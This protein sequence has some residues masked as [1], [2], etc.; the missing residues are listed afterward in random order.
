MFVQEPLGRSCLKHMRTCSHLA[1]RV[2]RPHPNQSSNKRAAKHPCKNVFCAIA[3]QNIW[4]EFCAP[5]RYRFFLSRNNNLRGRKTWK[6]TQS[7]PKITGHRQMFAF[8][9]RIG[10]YLILQTTCSNN[11]QWYESPCCSVPQGSRSLHH[12]HMIHLQT[13][14]SGYV[15]SRGCKA[16]K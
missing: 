4:F 13:L 3:M 1:K 14:S 12:K 15:M 16:E 2:A 5:L 7:V 6:T 11:L 8:N 9:F 10:P